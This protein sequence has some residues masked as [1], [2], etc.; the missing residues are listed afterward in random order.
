MIADELSGVDSDDLERIRIVGPGKSSQLPAS[1]RPCL[2]PYDG[3]LNDHR[4]DLRGTAFDFAARALSHFAELLRADSRMCSAAVHAR[5]VRQSLAR[6][7]DPRPVE[8][9]RIDDTE[10]RRTI[11]RL[12]RAGLSRTAALSHLRKSLRLACEAERFAMIWSDEVAG[13]G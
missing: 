2:M 13:R 10:L 6:R 7:R 1:I 4:L 8:R 11:R 9:S 12:W 3:R 5:R